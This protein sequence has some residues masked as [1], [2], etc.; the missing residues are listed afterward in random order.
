MQI[1]IDVSE[2]EYADICKRHGRLSSLVRSG[3][4]LPKGHG[5]LIDADK[6]YQKCDENGW[7]DS[8]D[9]YYGGGLE[10]IVCE[11][12]TVVEADKEGADC[13]NDCEH[14]EWATCPKMEVDNA[15]SD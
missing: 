9:N 7:F 4:P 11:A 15:D 3:T 10:D 6:L 12:Q 8:D 5:R 13:D 2:K 1:V 14:C